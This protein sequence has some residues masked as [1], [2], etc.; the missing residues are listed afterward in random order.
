MYYVYRSP[1]LPFPRCLALS[2]IFNETG[3]SFEPRKSVGWRRS[4]YRFLSQ[5]IGYDPPTRELRKFNSCK[6]W[7]AFQHEFEA[8]QSLIPHVIDSSR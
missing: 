5:C 8:L 3:R 6:C 7:L 4:A 1:F 2:R